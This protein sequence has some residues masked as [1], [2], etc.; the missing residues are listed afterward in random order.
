[1]KLTVLYDERCA[2]CRRCR[3]WLRRQP[4][5]VEVELLGA[6]SAE[7]RARYGTL[8]WL[9]EELVVADDAGNVWVGSAAYVTALWA[10][11]RYRPW[12]YRLAAPSMAPLARRFFVFVSKRRDRLGGWLGGHGPE[13]SFCDPDRP[14]AP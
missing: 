7:A 10:T 4:C 3:D 6:G 13:C 11:A 12:S 1:V 2:L 14:V 8:P 9:G 5:L